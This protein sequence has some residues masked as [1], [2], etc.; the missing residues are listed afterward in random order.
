MTTKP[1]FTAKGRIRP[2]YAMIDGT[3]E[4]FKP[5]TYVLRFMRDGKPTWES[6]GSDANK[7][8]EVLER[9]N[10]ELQGKKLGVAEV[11]VPFR[12]QAPRLR[13]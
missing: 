10:H 8:L 1:A 6:I 3:A 13:H 2:G 9:K 11:E 12:S 5:V 7:A 4:Q